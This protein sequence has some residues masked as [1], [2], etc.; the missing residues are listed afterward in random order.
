MTLPRICFPQARTGI[1]PEWLEQGFLTW[2][3]LDQPIR[4]F[5][6]RIVNSFPPVEKTLC[7]VRPAVAVTRDPAHP[8]GSTFEI[9]PP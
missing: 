6:R 8:A 1:N 7:L 5:S 2:A 3:G 9:Q 4:V